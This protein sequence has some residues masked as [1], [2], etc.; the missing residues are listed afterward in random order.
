MRKILVQNERFLPL[1]NTDVE[2][3]DIA[4]GRSVGTKKT[5][6]RGV[7]EFSEQTTGEYWFRPKITRESGKAGG[8][9][10]SGNVH[11]YELPLSS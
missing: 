6:A 5:N 9:S 2:M 3:F 4:T 10:V 1:A 7:V 11:L 8:M